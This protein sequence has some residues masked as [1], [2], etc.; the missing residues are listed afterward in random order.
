M[1]GLAYLQKN[2]LWSLRPRLGV[3]RLSVCIEQRVVDP[4][5]NDYSVVLN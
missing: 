1:Q 4:I 3:N 2:S 5:G